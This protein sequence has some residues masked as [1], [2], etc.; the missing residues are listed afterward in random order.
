LIEVSQVETVACLTANQ[1]IE[2]QL[3]GARHPREGNRSQ[4]CAPQG[5]YKTQDDRYVAITVGTDAQWTAIS[6]ELDLSDSL[7]CLDLRERREE[8]D[9][10][11]E[12]LVRW[13]T[14][15]AA[16]EVVGRLLSI[17]VPAA[18]LARLPELRVNPQLLSREFYRTVSHPVSGTHRAPRPAAVF[19]FGELAM[20][21]A[22]TLGQHNEEVL[23]ELG[24]EADA[25]LAL[26]RDG[27]IGRM[28]NNA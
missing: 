27:V 28:A 8:H 24:L 18:T 26:E 13:T 9:S 4:L 17:G 20:G 1:V 11:D 12:V 25:V 22:P 6:K 21:P 15:R 3:T 23:A 16:H 14:G 19:S 7:R 5:I 10:L 2:Y